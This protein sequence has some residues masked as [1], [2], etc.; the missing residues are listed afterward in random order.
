MHINQFS[1]KYAHNK[2]RVRFMLKIDILYDT[3]EIPKT[4]L[5]IQRQCK[6]K[7]NATEMLGKSI[8]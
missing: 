4:K 8:D 1:Y 7:H 2:Q 3:F 6:R 5:T